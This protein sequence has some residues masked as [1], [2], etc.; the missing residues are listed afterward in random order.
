MQVVSSANMVIGVGAYRATDYQGE[1]I[2]TALIDFGYLLKKVALTKYSF[3]QVADLIEVNHDTANPK[4][5]EVVRVLREVYAL[6]SPS[7]GGGDT[8]A[9]DPRLMPRADWQT[10]QR[11]TN[12]Q[13]YQIYVANAGALG[14]KVKTYDEWLNS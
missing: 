2:K 13:E 7:A 9:D 4:T 1:V 8:P 14:W 5:A 10:Q 6:N 3:S 12:D 11:G